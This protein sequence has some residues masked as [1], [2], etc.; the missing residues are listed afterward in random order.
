MIKVVEEQDHIR[1][2][3]RGLLHLHI[4]VADL[5]GVQSWIERGNKTFAIEYTFSGGAVIT[6]EYSNKAHFETI[7][8]ALESVL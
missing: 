7:L 4:G 8:K 3:I 1:I 2:Y 6:S 5:V